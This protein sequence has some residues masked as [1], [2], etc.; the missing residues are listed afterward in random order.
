MMI[1]RKKILLSIVELF[2]GEL[3][4]TNFHKLLF[5]FSEKQTERKYVF[6]P[7]KYG[8]FSFQAMA[9]KNSLIKDGYLENSK[10][11]KIIAK[12]DNF[13]ITLNE[14]DRK[15]LQKI[16]LQFGE[17]STKDLIRYVYLNY[18]Y[19][20]INS[21]I[22]ANCLTDKE[23]KL[24]EKF[25]PRNENIGLFTIGYEGRSIEKYLNILIQQ[26]IKVL[27]DVRKNPLSR[28][29]GFAKRTLQN[30]CE[31]VNIKYIH[32]PELGIVSE[33]RKNLN[34]QTDYDNLF[35]YYEKKVLPTQKNAIK[36]IYSLISNYRRVALTCFE[37]M[38]RQCHRTRIAN[39]V[40]SL[41]ETIPLKHL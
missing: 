5:L 11:W 19:F 26:N 7:Y 37:A 32:L 2:G 29:Y 31:S 20:A 18:P 13:I 24:V 3:S 6:V 9:D 22:V 34:N 4:A 10:Y 28:K 30:A 14:N 27:C 1:Y 15:S 36:F 40:H 23:I 25:R 39:S 41:D 38:P 17:F 35:I 8:C 21:E 16:K 12:N 33:K